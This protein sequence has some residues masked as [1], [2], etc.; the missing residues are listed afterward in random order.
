MTY[1][2]TV[3]QASGARW[4]CNR[5]KA[6]PTLKIAKAVARDANE[7]RDAGVH[8]YGCPDCGLYHIGGG[9]PR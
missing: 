5:K 3:R 4:S 6:Y 2:G 1:T 9:R 7:K 8:A